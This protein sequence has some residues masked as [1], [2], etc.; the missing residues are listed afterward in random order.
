MPALAPNSMVVI[1]AN[2]T[3]YVSHDIPFRFR[4]STDFNYLTGYPEQDAVLLLTNCTGREEVQ[5][6][7]IHI[8]LMDIKRLQPT[9]SGED[10]E[11]PFRDADQPR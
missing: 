2:P 3:R 8:P 10:G 6:S 5:K 1:A 4:Q 7:H 9:P 11:H